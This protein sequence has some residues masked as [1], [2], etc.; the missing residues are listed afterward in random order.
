V[1]YDA[2][3]DEHFAHRL[4]DAR[5]SD[6]AAHRQG[7]APV[8]GLIAGPMLRLLDVPAALA[9]RQRWGPSA[10]L[11]FGLEVRDAIVAENDG[12][13][14]VDFDGRRAQ[15][16]RGDARPLLRLPVSV[17]GQVYA[18]ELRVSDALMLGRAEADGD[19]GAVDA[20]FRTDRCF[21]LLDEF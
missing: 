1:A 10:P 18:G 14:V 21:R 5:R 20:L 9:A 7:W 2:S 15:V 12:A 8:A 11:R 4:H 19:V 17:L 3:P 6:L 13:F 16:S